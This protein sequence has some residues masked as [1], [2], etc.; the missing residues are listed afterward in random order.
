MLVFISKL[1][2]YEYFLQILLELKEKLIYLFT[3]IFINK[4]YNYNYLLILLNLSN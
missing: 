3:N 4:Y 1:K 2:Y